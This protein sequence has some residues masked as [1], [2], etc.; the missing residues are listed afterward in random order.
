MKGKLKE[1]DRLAEVGVHETVD[2]QVALAKKRATTSWHIDHRK[3]GI[4]ARFVAR[5]FKGDEAMYDA[6]TPSSTPSTERIIDYLSLKKSYHTFTTEVTNAYVHVDEECY[7]D[8]PAERLEQQVALGN[9][10]SVLW[11]M[12]KQL[13]GRRRAGTCWVDF[14]AERVE[15]Q[16]VDRCEAAPQFFVNYALDVSMWVHVD[17]LRG[18]GPKPPLDLVRANISQTIRFKV[19]TVYEMGTRYEHLK[20]ER[21]L[22]EDRP[23]SC[24]TRTT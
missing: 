20:R 8:P 2:L 12:R 24:P 10:L 4:R 22:H 11:R 14:L 18:T 23:I 17:D 6:F 1:L 3:G 21:V 15:E 16:S 7:V 19:W 13:Y 9:P 5:E